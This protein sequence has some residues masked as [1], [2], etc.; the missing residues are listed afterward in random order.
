MTDVDP[1][2][3]SDEALFTLRLTSAQ[4][5][6]THTA[7]KIFYDDLGHEERDVQRVLGEVLAKLPSADEIRAIDLGRELKQRRASA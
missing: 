3:Q 4:L 2:P 7:L 1:D 5:K 6:V